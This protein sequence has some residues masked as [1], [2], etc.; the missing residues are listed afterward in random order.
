MEKRG[1]RGKKCISPLSPLRRLSPLHSTLFPKTRTTTK[2][3][4]IPTGNDIH[5]DMPSPAGIEPTTPAKPA[6]T[7]A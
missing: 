7:S 4:T 3:A 1:L 2:S 5:G 6:A